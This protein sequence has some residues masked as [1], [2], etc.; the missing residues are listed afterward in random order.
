MAQAR[1]PFFERPGIV[2]F[3]GEMIVRPMTLDTWKKKG[4]PSTSASLRYQNAVR[5]I[6]AYTVSSDQRTGEYIVRVPLGYNES[7]FSNMLMFSGDY[8]YAVPNW[9]C[10][11]TAI[12]NDP[13][14][15]QQWHHPKIQA[16][17]AW[18]LITG[19][20]TI[21]C[22]I[23]DTGI[24]TDHPDL[25]ANRVP[26]FNSNTNTEESSG[27]VVE[28]D[29]GHGTHCAGDA[30]AIG[31]NG[32]GVSG[33]G[34]NFKIM[35]IKATGGGGGASLAALTGGVRWAVDHGAKVASVSFTGVDSPAVQTT[36][37]YAK[38]KGGLM[39]WAA[40]NDNR[41]L[42]FNHPD[43]IVV[44]ASDQND[45]KAGFSAF[46]PGVHVFAPGVNILS[47]TMGG[48]FGNASG[49][50]MATPVTNGAIAMIWAADPS[51][52]PD[53]VQT[54]LED[55]CDNIG[56]ANIFGHGRINVFKAVDAASVVPDITLAPQSVNTFEGSYMDGNL[57]SITFDDTDYYETRATLVSKLGFTTSVEFSF[58]VSTPKDKLRSVTY[59]VLARQMNAP[60][61]TGLFFLWNYQT[62]KYEHVG[63]NPIKQTFGTPI[64]RQI[65]DYNKYISST[66]QVK[67]LVRALAPISRGRGVAFDFNLDVAGMV[68]KAKR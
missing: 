60:S 35:G 9:M 40:G 62:G 29:N 16:P 68:V 8:E 26:G 50:S 67:V 57:V 10:Y 42:T 1:A 31:N 66:G 12:P 36:G 24:D 53:E 58:N 19:D 46:G 6:Q 41:N 44:G 55:N 43:V 65:G 23:I 22:A 15:S 7:T 59:S 56:P 63:S 13:L 51:L 45:Q 38:T 30:A 61:V 25:A 49:T 20:S 39:C 32:V 27:G 47:T 37:A 4:L 11:T 48:G 18:D 21:I 64:V 34:W 17:Q 3:T 33:V 52:T 14:F 5:R 2:E 54:I 28:D